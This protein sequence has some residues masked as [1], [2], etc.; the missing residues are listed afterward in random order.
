MLLGFLTVLIMLAVA[1]AYWREGIFTACVMFVNV[2]FAGLVAFNFWEPLADLLD[3]QFQGTFLKG[4]EDS[5]CLVGLFAVTL[6][7]LRTVTNALAR[8]EIRFVPWLRQAGGALF[9]LATG[10]VLSGF[11]LCVLQTL[12][13]HQ[14]FMFFEPYEPDQMGLRRLLPPD[15]VWLAMMHRAGAYGFAAAE[16]PQPPDTDDRGDPFVRY[17]TFDKYGTFE[18]RYLRYRRYSDERDSLE[19]DGIFDL[20]LHK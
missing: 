16:D 3:E 9:G 13:W 4:Y 2:F 7:A 5:L 6:G 18:L 8:T 12:P 15:R 1:Y 11:L 20:Q 10:Y 19:Y 17:L 14:N